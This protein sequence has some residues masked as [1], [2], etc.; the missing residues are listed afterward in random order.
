[1][2]NLNEKKP[3]DDKEL[4]KSFVAQLKVLLYFNLF[5]TFI[6]AMFAVFFFNDKTVFIF[7]LILIVV[8]WIYVGAKIYYLYRVN[9][10]LLEDIKE[11]EKKDE[12]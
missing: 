5:N 9:K 4:Q 8:M 6:I 3:N 11:E 1:M 2:N 10:K 12:F 7:L